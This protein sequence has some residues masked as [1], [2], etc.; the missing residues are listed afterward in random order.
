MGPFDP[1]DRRAI[2]QKAE[3]DLL[4]N[5]RTYPAF[6]DERWRAGLKVCFAVVPG[7]PFGDGL[8]SGCDI[9]LRVPTVKLS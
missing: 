8:Q 7:L 1:P 4:A 6:T 9:R 3:I 5:Q 2:I